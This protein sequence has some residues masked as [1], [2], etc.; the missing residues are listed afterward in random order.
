MTGLLE[1]A[2]AVLGTLPDAE[3]DRAAKVLLAFAQER[4]DYALDA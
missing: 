1:E 3:Q 2:L 4:S